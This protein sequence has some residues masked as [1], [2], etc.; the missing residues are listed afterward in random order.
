VSIG[1]TLILIMNGVM[2]LCKKI[3]E[4][5]KVNLSYK[6]CETIPSEKKDQ[7]P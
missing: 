3:F 1:F 4:I 5:G 6:I 7:N 2:A